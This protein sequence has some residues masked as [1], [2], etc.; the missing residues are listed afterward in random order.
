MI[1]I[2]PVE[3]VDLEA[4]AYACWSFLRLRFYFLTYCTHR[5]LKQNSKKQRRM[6]QWNT[7]LRAWTSL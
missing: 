6:K 7:R 4:N 1:K 5:R 3:E 2:I